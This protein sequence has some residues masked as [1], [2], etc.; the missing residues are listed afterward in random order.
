MKIET[1]RFGEIEVDS[2]AVI[3]M[4]EG[5]IGMESANQLCLI[6]E[7]PER[8]FKW[9]QVIGEPALA[10]IAIDPYDFYPDYECEISDKDAGVLGIEEAQDAAALVLLTIAPD[11]REVTAN[12][13]AP[14]VVCAKT[15]TAKQ[16]ILQNDKYT[17]KHLLSA[18][19]QNSAYTPAA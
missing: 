8:P 15:Q 12:L 18:G 7:S 14:L 11:G 13:V 2:T 3:S 9:L 6:E 10:F 5:L 19:M 16:V 17:T 4:P 1:L